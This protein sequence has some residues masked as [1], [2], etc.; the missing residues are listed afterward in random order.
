MG[1]IDEDDRFID[2][3]LERYGSKKASSAPRGV[4][5]EPAGR[6]GPT[7]SDSVDVEA[8][9][10]RREN[11]R[12]RRELAMASSSAGS[13]APTPTG[14]GSNGGAGPSAEARLQVRTYF[15]ISCV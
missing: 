14:G 5:S 9:A 11:E 1:A 15:L 12:L 3:I 13:A 10:L 4:V 7:A 6:P 8:A 2:S